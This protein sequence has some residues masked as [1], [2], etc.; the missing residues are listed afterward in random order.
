MQVADDAE[1]K[2]DSLIDR[3]VNL[4]IGW[5]E[6]ASQLGVTRQAARRPA[7]LSSA[8]GSAI[9]GVAEASRYDMDRDTGER[10]A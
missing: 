10:S 8:P 6:I 9:C 7:L 2:L 3:A 5:P 1:A 4:G